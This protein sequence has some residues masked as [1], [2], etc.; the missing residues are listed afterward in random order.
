MLPCLCDVGMAPPSPLLG[1]PAD[2]PNGH[3]QWPSLPSQTSHRRFLVVTCSLGA[4]IFF[5]SL[6]AFFKGPDTWSPRDWPCLFCGLGLVRLN[7][8]RLARGHGRQSPDLLQ[9]ALA[10]GHLLCLDF[11][12]QIRDNVAGRRSSKGKALEHVLPCSKNGEKAHWLGREYEREQQ[13]C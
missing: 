3:N 11:L 9:L 8:P 5:F 1:A 13:M 2:R 4:F 6:R 12:M 7:I 10:S